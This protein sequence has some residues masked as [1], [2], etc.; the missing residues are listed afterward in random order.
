MMSDKEAVL[1]DLLSLA[2]YMTEQLIQNVQEKS[3]KL[4]LLAQTPPTLLEWIR[5]QVGPFL[6]FLM[7][8][9]CYSNN[10]I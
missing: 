3:S 2:G 7:L 9:C 8:S 5:K 1:G 10:R 6:H 4:S